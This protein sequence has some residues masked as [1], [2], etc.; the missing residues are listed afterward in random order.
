MLPTATWKDPLRVSL[1][2]ELDRMFQRKMCFRTFS[3]KNGSFF[4][5]G[6]GNYLA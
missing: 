1:A 3:V 2:E 5:A 6:V 4:K